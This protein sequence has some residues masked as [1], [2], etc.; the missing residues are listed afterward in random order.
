MNRVQHFGEA[1]QPPRVTPLSRDRVGVCIPRRR[2]ERVRSADEP[3]LGRQFMGQFGDREVTAPL[4]APVARYRDESIPRF[5]H[6][7]NAC[8]LPTDRARCVRPDPILGGHERVRHRVTELRPRFRLIDTQA[9]E[10]R[11]ATC[12]KPPRTERDCDVLGRIFKQ[13]GAMTCEMQRDWHRCCATHANRVAFDA[14]ASCHA[15][16]LIRQRI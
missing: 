15:L 1:L 16:V 12:F 13:H 5:P 10:I 7:R 3:T 9:G 14:H 6:G 2:V 4:E 11:R 8:C